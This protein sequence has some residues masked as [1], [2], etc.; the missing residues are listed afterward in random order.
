[1]PIGA[2]FL[3]VRVSMKRRADVRSHPKVASRPAFARDQIVILGVL[4][5]TLIVYLRCARNGFVSDDQ[6]LIV[7][8][9]HLR[10][11]SFLWKSLFRDEYWFRDPLHLPGSSRYR[12]LLLLWF[13]L[14][15]QI[16]G[17]DAAGWHLAMI[18]AHLMVVFLV[19]RVAEHL[20]SERYVG[21]SAA[22]LFGVLPVH[23]EAVVWPAGFGLVL[24]GGFELAAL[25]LFMERGRIG[26]RGWIIA[27]G[28]YG[29]ALFSHE[30]AASFPGL[31]AAY[32]F[33]I[34]SRGETAGARW[35]KRARR[36]MACIAPFAVEL[37][38]YFVARRLVLGFLMTDPTMPSN[39]ATLASVL[40]TLPL[41]L[42]TYLELLTVPWMQG[43]QHQVLF[44][45]SAASLDFLAPLIT[46]GV[47]GLGF[48]LAVRRDPR[49]PLYLFCAAW[50]G[51]AL[52]PVLS[53]GSLLPEHLVHDNYLYLSS[54]GW[55]VI[56]GDCAL[57][58]ARRGTSARRLV[59]SVGGA[60]MVVYAATLWNVQH[61]FY[62]DWVY[63][64]RCAEMFPRAA[65]PHVRLA[66]MLRQ[67][68]DL[69]GA[70]RELEEALSL[71][72]DNGEALYR[73]GFVHAKMGRVKEG[74]GET[75]EGLLRWMPAHQELETY[76]AVA[77]LYDQSGDRARSEA[78]LTHAQSLPGG[79]PATELT[80]ASLKITDGDPA[81][82]EAIARDLAGRYP[83]DP[84]VWVELGLALAG[85]G[86]NDEALSAY[87]SALKLA[88]ADPAVNSVTAATLHKLGR[89][90]EALQYCRTAIALAPNDQGARSLMAE[91]QLDL[92]KH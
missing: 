8:N 21:W 6:A 15:Y 79:S 86:R 78:A 43:P 77:R 83:Y 84:R 76:L 74:A 25:Y 19:F 13:G 33:L 16:F 26:R 7:G 54:V 40:M 62:D 34:E 92:S 91:I 65:G 81:A 3:P 53:L 50:M 45:T 82:A 39:Q 67:R 35:A 87:Q 85:Q 49:R 36:T 14:N 30:C 75:A 90:S 31:I 29:A 41:V 2:V 56:V 5:V 10:H 22:L 11:W 64:T 60:A 24:S 61:F 42:A 38:M 72:P 70:E 9:D 57:R 1:M 52:A 88:P 4:L 28:L 89:D 12:P 47:L 73:L 18:A 23:A 46:L 37:V 32:V 71:D 66:M 69:A 58:L 55:C 63:Y 59:W 44:V 68:D 48:Y 20:T 80:R 51:I 27:M 17:L